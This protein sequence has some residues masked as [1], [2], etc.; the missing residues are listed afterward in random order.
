[1][2][3]N[4]SLLAH[5]LIHSLATATVNHGAYEILRVSGARNVGPKRERN[6]ARLASLVGGSL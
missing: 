4:S 6:P 3:V 1:M 5:S 2:N